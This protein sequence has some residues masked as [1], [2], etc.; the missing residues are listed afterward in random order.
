[1]LRIGVRKEANQLKAHAWVEYQG[2]V[3]NDTF[4]V[5]NRYSP[6]EGSI[7]ANEANSL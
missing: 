4:D 3:L 2:F 5:Q 7:L 6:F 1:D